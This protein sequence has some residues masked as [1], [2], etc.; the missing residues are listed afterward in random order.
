M[1]DGHESHRRLRGDRAQDQNDPSSRSTSTFWTREE[2]VT[3]P[4]SLYDSIS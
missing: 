4:V 1:V 3:T 2:V